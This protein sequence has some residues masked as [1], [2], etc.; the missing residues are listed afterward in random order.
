MMTF[1]N[2]NLSTLLSKPH[3]QSKWDAN[4]VGDLE[5]V[6]IVFQEFGDGPF[7]GGNTKQIKSIKRQPNYNIFGFPWWKIPDFHSI[8]ELLTSFI[9]ESLTPIED[10]MAI[11]SSRHIFYGTR[12]A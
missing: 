5:Q 12:F 9:R 11:L 2:E 7:V 6:A 4:L 3:V 10:K 1:L 8:N